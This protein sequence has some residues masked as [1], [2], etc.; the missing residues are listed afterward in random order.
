MAMNR[1][2]HLLTIAGEECSETQQ[3]CS[4]ALRFTM[5]EIHPDKIENPYQATNAERILLE[6]NDLCGALELLYD[7]RIEEL[8]D[9]L[10]IIDKK[11]KIEKFLEY[12]RERGTLI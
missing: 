2:E 4:K 8:L 9:R 7:C 1:L 11:N 5:E 12:S 10:K 6:F 3:R